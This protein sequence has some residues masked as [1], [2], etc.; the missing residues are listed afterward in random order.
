MIAITGGK[1]GCGKTTVAIGLA[2]ALVRDGRRPLLADAD[3]AMPDLH[4]RTGT[5]PEPGLAALA[6][7]TAPERIAHESTTCPGVAVV[8]AGGTTAVP[9]SA[10]EALSSLVRPVIL[11]CPAGAGPDVATPLRAAEACVVV[12]TTDDESRQ[13]ASKTAAMAASLDTPVAAV[14]QRTT[15]IDQAADE[16]VGARTGQAASERRGTAAA[17]TVRIPTV[18]GDPLADARTRNRFADLAAAIWRDDTE[19]PGTAVPSDA[20]PQT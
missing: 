4:V 1:G 13:D 11:D 7:G 2:A 20:P 5:D 19:T 3:V 10:V 18:D 14:V 12:T 9:P 8:P 17:A 15:E 6:A 16:A